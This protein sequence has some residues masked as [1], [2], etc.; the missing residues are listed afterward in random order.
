MSEVEEK[1]TVV[2]E[3]DIPIEELAAKPGM[4]DIVARAAVL[5]DS[6]RALKELEERVD[7]QEEELLPLMREKELHGIRLPD[8]AAVRRR[9]NANRPTIDPV[10]LVGRIADARDYFEVRVVVDQAKLHQEYPSVWGELGG[11][12]TEGI[13]VF[14]PKKAR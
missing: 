7:R 3:P 13:A 1:G 11:K 4:G 10:K 12:S 2:E 5:V 9:W 6:R 8:G 14:E